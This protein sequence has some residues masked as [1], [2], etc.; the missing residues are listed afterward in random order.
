[1][2]RRLLHQKKG[3]RQR[4]EILRLRRLETNKQQKQ[5]MKMKMMKTLEK[6][7]KNNSVPQ[8]QQNGENNDPT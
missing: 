5:N 4:I 3:V 2:T 1:M 6:K 8:D 7:K